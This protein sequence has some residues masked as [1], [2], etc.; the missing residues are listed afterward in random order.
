MYICLHVYVCVCMYVYV[1]I[2]IHTDLYVNIY[3]IEMI[4][5]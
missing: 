2:Y 1:Y 3:F 4:H 5:L